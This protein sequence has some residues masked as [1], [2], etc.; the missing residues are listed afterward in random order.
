MDYAS[1][2]NV[3][4]RLDSAAW[5]ARRLL[6]PL[7]ALHAVRRAAR[8]MET[9]CSDSV[10]V[11]LAGLDDTVS[12]PP[13]CPAPTTAADTACAYLALASAIL[14]SRAPIALRYKI[15]R[16]AADVSTEHVYK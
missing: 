9:V 2:A 3:S 12:A 10:S 8:A 16:R 14:A 5:T 11:Y 4:A 6:P 1:E 13:S 15:A 7:R